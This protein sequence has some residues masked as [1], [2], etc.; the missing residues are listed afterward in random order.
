MTERSA[1]F[2]E[3]KDGVLLSP[4]FYSQRA[5]EDEVDIIDQMLAQ[6]QSGRSNQQG[7]N[8]R[9][10]TKRTFADS[11]VQTDFQIKV[12]TPH[13]VKEDKK[14]NPTRYE[15]CMNLFR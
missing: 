1:N 7:Q 4:D 12:I 10:D 13:Y 15:Q 8:E 11:S 9:L 6:A 14:S 5:G 2:S 3:N